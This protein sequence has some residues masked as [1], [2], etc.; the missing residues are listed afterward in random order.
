[1]ESFALR[2]VSV[3][4]AGVEAGGLHVGPARLGSFTAGPIDS[5]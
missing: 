3:N 2:L 1:M 4:I 5:C